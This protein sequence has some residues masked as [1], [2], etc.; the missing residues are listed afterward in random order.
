MTL[1]TLILII[2]PYGSIPVATPVVVP[3]LQSV[4]MCNKVKELIKSDYKRIDAYC[5]ETVK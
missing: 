2:M 1:Y 4:E 3:N 5:V